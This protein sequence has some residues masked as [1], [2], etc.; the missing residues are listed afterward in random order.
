MVTKVQNEKLKIIHL[1]KR[2]LWLAS[3]RKEY[4]SRRG[5]D[6]DE[7]EEVS[8]CRVKKVLRKF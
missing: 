6:G 4:Q 5:W 2:H 1:P 3:R 8:E 7:S